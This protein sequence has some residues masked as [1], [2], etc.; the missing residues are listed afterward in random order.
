MQ[1]HNI[2]RTEI[3]EAEAGVPEEVPEIAEEVEQ[4]ISDQD[5]VAAR[6]HTISTRIEN[7]KHHVV[8]EE[9]DRVVEQGEEEVG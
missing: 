1:H 8:D 6:T 2:N 5:R 3:H 9:V 7:N 4:P